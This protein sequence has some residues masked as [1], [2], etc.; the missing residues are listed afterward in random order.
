[1]M[2]DDL[3]TKIPIREH[4]K[5][6]LKIVKH[7]RRLDRC[8]FPVMAVSL[9]LKTAVPYVELVL[10]AYILDG[11][12]AHR[13]I[14]EMFTVITGTTLAVMLLQFL[15]GAQNGSAQGANVLFV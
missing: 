1:M 7:V 14:G 5:N 10:T 12:G 11:I 2:T 4:G 13:E 3:L 9:A 8:Y 6:I 15:S